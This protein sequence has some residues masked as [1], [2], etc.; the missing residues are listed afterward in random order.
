MIF[1]AICLL[2]GYVAAAFYSGGMVSILFRYTQWEN[3]LT[4]VVILFW[5]ALIYFGLKAGKA[6]VLYLIDYANR[7]SAINNC[8]WPSY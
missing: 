5:A 7:R 2:M 8:K 1:K 3:V 6:S 4:Y